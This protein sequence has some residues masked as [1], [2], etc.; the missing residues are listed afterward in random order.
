MT[1]VSPL[2]PGLRVRARLKVNTPVSCVITSY[3]IHYTKLYEIRSGEHSQTAFAFGLIA[4]WAQ[5]RGDVGLAR[6]LEQ[7]GRSFY[8][9]NFV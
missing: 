8:R 7:R 1:V 5:V 2:E 4:D 9:N 6:L 3:S